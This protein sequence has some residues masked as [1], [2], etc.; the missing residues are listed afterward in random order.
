MLIVVR[1]AAYL[2]Q[3]STAASIQEGW[4]LWRAAVLFLKVLGFQTAAPRN[5]GDLHS[6]ADFLMLVPSSQL[7]PRTSVAI[8]GFKMASKLLA[9]N[10]TGSDNASAATLLSL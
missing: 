7:L 6:A 8:V 1:A 9:N 5:C 2:L 4:K 10:S 3:K